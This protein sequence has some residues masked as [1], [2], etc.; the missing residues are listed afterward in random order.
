MGQLILATL[1]AFSSVAA[2][3]LFQGAPQPIPLLVMA[4]A[5][6]AAF[7]L[8]WCRSDARR[9]MLGTPLRWTWGRPWLDS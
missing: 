1:I 4:F 8:V 9:L 5:F 2:F 6:G 3:P 7:L